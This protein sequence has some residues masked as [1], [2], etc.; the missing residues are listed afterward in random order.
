MFPDVD[1]STKT[2][3]VLVFIAIATV[4]AITHGL[5]TAV[6]HIACPGLRIR[7]KDRENDAA[8][9]KCRIIPMD[10]ECIR[11]CIAKAGIGGIKA[12]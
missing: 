6:G 4:G 3:K 8:V 2:N 11:G 10:R 1:C 7:Q 9:L 5:P 12:S